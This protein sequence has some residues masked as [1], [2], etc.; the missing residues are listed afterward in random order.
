MAEEKRKD[1]SVSLR[2]NEDLVNAIDDA[3]EQYNISR[4]EVLRESFSMK[5]FVHRRMQKAMELQA[6]QDTE[7]NKA[8]YSR[9]QRLIDE[10]KVLHSVN[11]MR[12]LNCNHT[13]IA[14]VQEKYSHLTSEPMCYDKCRGLVKI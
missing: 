7:F 11:E 10:E 1:K 13:T 8:Q 14:H 12:C 6:K 2:L 5:D 9:M 3:A 4:S